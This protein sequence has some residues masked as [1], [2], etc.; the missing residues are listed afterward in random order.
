[1]V[2]VSLQLDATHQTNPNGGVGINVQI[3]DGQVV[4]DP[5]ATADAGTTPAAKPTPTPTPTP[6]ATTGTVDLLGTP[7]KTW[8]TD[9][10]MSVAGSVQNTWGVAK[11]V[12]VTA[13]F[14]KKN[15]LGGSTIADTQSQDL[16]TVAGSSSAAFDIASPVKLRNL[17]GQ[18]GD[19]IVTVGTL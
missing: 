12:K 2:P 14:Y 6:S 1:M 13:T 9:G 18:E 8:L 7:T 17:W 3:S 11:H 10:T 4:V 16:G 15:L 5:I 19:V